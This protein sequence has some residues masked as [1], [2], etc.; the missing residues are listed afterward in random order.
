MNVW[1]INCEIE[2]IAIFYF[3]YL[4]IP[5][6]TRLDA[7]HLAVAAFHKMDYLIS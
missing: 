3:D 6:K 1:G 2:N 7:V 4:Q 5:D